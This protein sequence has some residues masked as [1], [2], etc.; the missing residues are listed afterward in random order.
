MTGLELIQD[1]QRVYPES[2]YFSH[3]L[4]FV[5]QPSK[6]DLR[7]PY[8][9]KMPK[10]NIGQQGLEKSF[11][12]NLIGKAGNREIE[13]NSLGRTI[14]E[15]SKQMSTK[16]ENITLTFDIGLQKYLHKQLSNHRAGSIVV[17]DIVL[18]LIH[19]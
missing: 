6:K 15:I 9:L 18:S 8:I 17:I 2:Q 4:G 7:L 3:I 12:E 11:N 10:L 14:R 19:I 1:F 16:G 13:V 5:N